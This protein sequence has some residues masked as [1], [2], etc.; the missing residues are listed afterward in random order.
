M[1]AEERRRLGLDGVA[2]PGWIGPNV[3]LWSSQAAMCQAL[4]HH[5][6]YPASY[7]LLAA[8]WLSDQ[9]FADAGRVGPYLEPT[10]PPTLGH[11]PRLLGFD[12][13]DGSMTSGLSNCGYSGAERA[14][15]ARRWSQSLN[16]NHLFIRAEEAFAFRDLT[17]RRVV[18]H[19]PFFVYGL[20]VVERAASLD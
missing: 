15:L 7:I 5:A 11:E 4:E 3:G 13:A 2:L 10:A 16:D 14:S 12:V 8:T 18:E 1:S 17:N 9:A 6:L 19:A 20:Y